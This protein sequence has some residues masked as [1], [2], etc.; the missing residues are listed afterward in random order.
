VWTTNLV[1]LTFGFAML[2]SFLLIPQLLQLPVATGHGFG[3]SVSE[4]G[5]YLL[6]SSVGM[7]VFVPVS[8]ALDRRFGAKVPLVLGTIITAA[9]F[10]VPAIAH[11]SVWQ[12]LVSSALMGIGVGLAFAAMPNAIVAAVPPTQTGVA[13][14]VNTITR[15]IGGSIG[16]AALAAILGS[17]HVPTDDAFTNSFWTGPACSASRS[18]APSSS[19]PAQDGGKPMPLRTRKLREH[20]HTDVVGARAVHGGAGWPRPSWAAM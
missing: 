4:A 8:G 11:D 13:T 1:G 3:L 20:L 7:L 10:G 18:S 6:P 9:S 19:L 16:T 17:G 12:L 5:L 15:T 2:G 14:S